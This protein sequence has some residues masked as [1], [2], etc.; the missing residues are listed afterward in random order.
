MPARY[1]YTLSKTCTCGLK[2]TVRKGTQAVPVLRQIKQLY[3]K[4][5]EE[6][7]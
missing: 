6:S 2:I 7:S 4:I 3:C 1:D 5:A